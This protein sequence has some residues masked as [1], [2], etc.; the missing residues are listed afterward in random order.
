MSDSQNYTAAA[1]DVVPA[2][3]KTLKDVV[4]EDLEEKG[5][6]RDAWLW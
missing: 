2:K 6:G 1:A 4:L 3:K 5:K